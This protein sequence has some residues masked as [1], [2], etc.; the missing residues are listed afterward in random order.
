MH[1]FI[2]K[3]ARLFVR[4][5]GRRASRGG[6]A[7]AVIASMSM[8]IVLGAPLAAAQAATPT[9]AAKADYATGTTP[10]SV[11]VADLGNGK[12]DLVVANKGSNTVSVLLGKGDGTYGG[13]VDYK[14]GEAPTAVAVADLNG[15]SKHRSS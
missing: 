15:N 3:R 2:A 7:G 10:Q 1:H 5:P 14:T 8:A 11:A 13:K 6:Y 9:F 4:G 12:Q